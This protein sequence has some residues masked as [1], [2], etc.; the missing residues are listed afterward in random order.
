MLRG[1]TKWAGEGESCPVPAPCPALPHSPAPRVIPDPPSVPAPP[2][3]GRIEPD[4]RSPTRAHD[5]HARHLANATPPSSPCT[6]RRRVS[7]TPRHLTP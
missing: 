1:R 4:S 2:A 6:P 5:Q 7:G 3:P